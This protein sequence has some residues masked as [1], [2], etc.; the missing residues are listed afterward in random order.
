MGLMCVAGQSST[1]KTANSTTAKKPATTTSSKTKKAKSGKHVAQ[2]R[3]SAPRQSAPTAER[4]R[5]IQQALTDKGYGAGPVDGNWGT[6]WVDALKKFQAG[7][8]L[9]SD[10]KLGSLSL[11]AL[12]LGPKREP[13]ADLAGKPEPIE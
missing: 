13:M 3:R 8:N 6:E 5:E 4:Y 1:K 12:G 11:I 7:H 10:G 2:T 9:N